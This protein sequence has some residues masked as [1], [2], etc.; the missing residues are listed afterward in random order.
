VATVEDFKRKLMICAA[1]KCTRCPS[2]KRTIPEDCEYLLKH[3]LDTREEGVIVYAPRRSG[4][5]QKVLDRAMEAVSAGQETMVLVNH[6]TE[7]HRLQ[8]ASMGSGLTFAHVGNRQ[9]VERYLLG[10][11]GWSV[12]SDG[13]GEWVIGA[14]HEA[15]CHFVLGYK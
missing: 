9:D 6:R 13:L 4:K 15:G 7:I 2:H 12:F 5:T 10:R 14:V 8:R 3:V 1:C 11:T